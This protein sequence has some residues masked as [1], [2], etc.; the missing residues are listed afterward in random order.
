MRNQNVMRRITV[1][2]A[3]I[4]A[5][6]AL[7]AVLAVAGLVAPTVTAGAYEEIGGDEEFIH[8][9]EIEKDWLPANDELVTVDQFLG[10]KSYTDDQMSLWPED[11]I[12]RTMYVR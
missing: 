4:V 2:A 1:W 10:F 9:V 11:G 12:G 3:G 6:L 8:I 7:V 5:L